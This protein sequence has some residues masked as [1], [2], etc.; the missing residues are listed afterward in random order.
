MTALDSPAPADLEVN[1]PPVGLEV[2]VPPAG[3]EVV[4]SRYYI[5]V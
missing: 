2:S 5:P 4:Q 1:N 3:L